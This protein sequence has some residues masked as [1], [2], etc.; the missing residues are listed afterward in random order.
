MDDQAFLHAFETRLF[1]A[2]D[3]SHRQHIRLAWLVLRRDG[4]TAGVEA[5]RAGILAFAKRYGVTDKYHDTLTRFWAA[6]VQG[7][8]DATPEID[9]YDA[10]VEQHPHLLNN[11]ITNE[12][13]SH[14]VL[15]SDAARAGW[16]AP[17]LRGMPE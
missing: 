6:M 5:L 12:Y 13:Y 2:A 10:F 1:P 3:F 7:A 9:T 8:I 14:D 15:F 17:D 16:V 4:Y 11:H